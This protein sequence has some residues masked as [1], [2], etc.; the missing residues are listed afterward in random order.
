[1]ARASHRSEM[2]EPSNIWHYAA[3]WMMFNPTELNKFSPTTQGQLYSRIREYATTL[4]AQDRISQAESIANR[5]YSVT[6]RLGLKMIV[7]AIGALTFGQGFWLL[8]TQI[9]ER[10]EL[11]PLTT[12]IGGLVTSTAVDT[13]ATRAIT[14]WNLRRDL[15]KNLHLLKQQ[16]PY[17]HGSELVDR[18]YKAQRQLIL[19]VE[20]KSKVWQIPIHTLA[21][22]TL[23]ATE[24]V[25]TRH[26]VS[27]A[28]FMPAEVK[29]AIAALPVI[30]TWAI[31]ILQSEY[32]ER[33]DYARDLIQRYE[34]HILPSTTL[35]S[36]ERNNWAYHRLY[37]DGRFDAFLAFV[38]GRSPSLM[39][40]NAQMACA[41]YDFDYCHGRIRQLVQDF[42][43]ES[44]CLNE[45][46]RENLARLPSNAIL[47]PVMT[48]DRSDTEIYEQ[49]MRREQA[50]DRWI[51]THRPKLEEDLQLKLAELRAY[52][53][54]EISRQYLKRQ[55]ARR[56]YQE[57]Y[58]QWQKLNDE[59][60]R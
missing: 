60:V 32:F 27:Y 47:P 40:K 53:F 38:L 1:M 9:V 12:L 29:F 4:I 39:I 36:E 56:Q 30:I 11:V 26:V 13:L 52:F 8:A 41:W 19:M 44:Q 54:D 18:F 46:Y 57:G 3:R 42:K 34:R 16:Q 31:A 37:E 50:S 7:I 45:N 17:S 28:V 6:T 22:I 15:H 35:S 33:P 51:E 49:Q 10:S 48:E 20:G 58:V 2:P 21:A 24:F 43:A 55:A 14:N 25:I 23:S 5:H 59:A